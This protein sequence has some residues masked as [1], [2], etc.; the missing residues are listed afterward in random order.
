MSLKIQ[1]EGK[2]AVVRTKSTPLT[3][4]EIK[5]TQMQSFFDE[6][7]EAMH[8][9]DGIGIASCQVGTAIRVFAI[10]GDYT[11]S[12]EDEVYVNPRFTYTSSNTQHIEEGCL[13]VP[14]VFGPVDRAAKVRMKA[15]DRHG[16][17]VLVKAKGMLAI[18]LQHEMDHLDATVFIDKARHLNKERTAQRSQIVL[19]D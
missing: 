4:D 15:K 9:Y 14:G 16:E 11:P 1:I 3:D 2:D 18:I 12:G 17:T 13:S 7:L 8:R 5:S 6:L 19:N 10:L